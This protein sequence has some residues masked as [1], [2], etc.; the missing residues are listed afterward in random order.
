MMS[1]ITLHKDALFSILSFLPRVKEK[2]SVALVCH[3][4]LS[5]LCDHMKVHSKISAVNFISRLPTFTDDRL[6]DLMNKLVKS[7]ESAVDRAENLKQIVHF[8]KEFRMALPDILRG[9]GIEGLGH[10]RRQISGEADLQEFI[11]VVASSIDLACIDQIHFIEDAEQRE[12]AIYEQLDALSFFQN[13][14]SVA[15][16]ELKTQW[17]LF[18]NQLPNSEDRSR[19]L[20]SINVS[21]F[22]ANNPNND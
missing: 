8:Q 13:D 11:R 20:S 10:L 6:I 19:L 21:E 22:K 1:S 18:I 15:R 5:H 3:K 4:W 2:C 14:G 17:I 12:N 16:P 9:I 7:F